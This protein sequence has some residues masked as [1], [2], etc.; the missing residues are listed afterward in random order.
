[1]RVKYALYNF[2]Q[3]I[4]LCVHVKS[5]FMHYFIKD[6]LYSWAKKQ[7]GFIVMMNKDISND[8]MGRVSCI[9]VYLLLIL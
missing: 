2:L 5:P 3:R 4:G 7:N 8:R 9:S 6:L 1:M